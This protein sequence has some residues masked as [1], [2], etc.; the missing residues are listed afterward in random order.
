MDLAD[1]RIE[2]QQ[3]ENSVD[4]E[5][6]KSFWPEYKGSHFQD[7]LVIRK[8]EKEQRRINR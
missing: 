3:M 1:A 5:S 4:D 8:A 7:K 2:K 6:L